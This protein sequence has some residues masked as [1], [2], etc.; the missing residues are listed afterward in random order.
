MKGFFLLAVSAA[1]MLGGSFLFAQEAGSAGHA[2][3]GNSFDRMIN[4]TIPAV[5]HEP[6]TSVVTAEW[7]KTLED[8]STVTRENHRV[9][10]RDGNGRIFQ[11]RRMLVPKGGQAESRLMRTEISDPAKRTKYFCRP[12]EKV[13]ALL[14]YEGPPA[15]V[16]E[17]V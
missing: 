10:V 16:L 5:Q 9:V 2:P 8:G 3:D 13:C 17:P 12:E 1:L 15:E 7:T 4:I 11:E 6:F 14:E